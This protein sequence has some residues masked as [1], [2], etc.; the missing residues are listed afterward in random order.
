M[1]VLIKC[2]NHHIQLHNKKQFNMKEQL[3]IKTPLL[4]NLQN[5]KNKFVILT[6]I[7]IAIIS[8]I[9]AKTFTQ[10]LQHKNKK[11]LEFL[12]VL[13]QQVQKKF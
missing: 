7:V 5:K 6:N 8:L 2:S 13:I 12:Q 3:I 10:A 4:D 9:H 11:H 1:K